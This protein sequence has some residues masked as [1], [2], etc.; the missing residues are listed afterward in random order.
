MRQQ[1]LFEA[2]AAAYDQRCVEAFQ[3][4][5]RTSEPGH[6]RAVLLAAEVDLVQAM[7][8]I[9]AA[10]G[11]QQFLRKIL[12]LQRGLW[13]D[14]R[15][16]AC[17]RFG[18]ARRGRV[19]RG[20][21]V[22]RAQFPTLAQHGLEDAPLGLQCGVAEAVAVGDPGL[23][24]RIVFARH[25]AH[26]LVTA[27][28]HE[29]VRADTIVRRYGSVLAE[30]PGPRGVTRGLGGQRADGTDVDDVS[31][32]LRDDGLFDIGADFHVLAAPGRAEFGHTGDFVAETHAARAVNTA[33]QIGRDQRPDVLVHHHA[34]GFGIF[35]HAL[36]ET[37]GHV[38]QL[39]FTALVTDR[40]VQRMVDQQKLHGRLLRRDC[41]GRTGL[42]HHTVH[43][44]RG[45]GRH[46]FRRALDLDQAHAAVGRNR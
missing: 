1:R 23:V 43:A 16:Q 20:F 4:R 3:R 21:P 42:D 22:D 39:A 25:H 46:G 7:V 29:Q 11:A 10:E 30:L 32:Q 19:Q 17:A 18:K 15:R 5:Q 45:A 35:G 14:Q 36:A 6:D 40:A 44:L 26:D 2:Q 41:P 34:F 12:F 24:D 13:T 37:H 31:R 8:D 38:L 9:V 27:R 33:G 28:V